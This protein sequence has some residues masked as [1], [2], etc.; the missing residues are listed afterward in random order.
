LEHREK[1][2]ADG[3]PHELVY[4]GFSLGVMPAQQRVLSFLLN[5]E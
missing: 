5:I 1:V 4:A 2:A 3:L